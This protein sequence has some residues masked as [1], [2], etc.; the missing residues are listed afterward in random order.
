MGML[1][2][3]EEGVLGLQTFAVST[4]CW[5]VL[6]PAWEGNQYRALYWWGWGRGLPLIAFCCSLVLNGKQRFQ[7]A[8]ATARMFDRW[9][10]RRGESCS[11]LLAFHTLVTALGVMLETDRFSAWFRSGPARHLLG[12]WNFRWWWGGSKIRIFYESTLD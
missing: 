2:F 12:V 1:H 11:C 6:P 4:P 9:R 7:Q 8:K 10:R 5:L 3:Q